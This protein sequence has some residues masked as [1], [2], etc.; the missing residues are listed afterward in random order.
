MLS[1]H[2]LLFVGPL[3]FYESGETQCATTCPDTQRF[4]FVPGNTYEYRYES[5]VL[6]NI[7]GATE[8][9]SALHMSATVRLEA[10]TQCEMA[11]SVSTS[12]SLFYSKT[13]YETNKFSC[14]GSVICIIRQNFSLFM[15]HK[16]IYYWVI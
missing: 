13:C 4:S 5:D 7:P 1:Y 12:S 8:E 14:N 16:I 15:G 2:C 11:I 3:N 6:T 9:S 10:L